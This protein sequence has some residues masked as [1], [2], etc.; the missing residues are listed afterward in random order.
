MNSTLYP[1][2]DKDSNIIKP[3]DFAKNEYSK[4][5]RLFLQTAE[6]SNSP[7]NY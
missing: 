2:T 4:F 3:I 6:E 7:R 1:I 5:K